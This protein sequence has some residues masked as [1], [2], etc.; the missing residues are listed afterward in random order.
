MYS[1]ESPR[2]GNSNETTQHKHKLEKL[3]KTIRIMSLVLALSLTLIGSNYPCLEHIIMVPNVFEPL[4]FGCITSV[5]MNFRFQF[6]ILFINAELL[7]L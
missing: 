4:K 3:E 2:R 1:L 7:I 6:A 5:C